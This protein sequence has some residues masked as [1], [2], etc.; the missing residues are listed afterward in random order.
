MGH[1]YSREFRG[2][3][4][5]A[6]GCS[7]WIFL[8]C[9]EATSSAAARACVVFGGLDADKNGEAYRDGG[10]R[11]VQMGRRGKERAGRAEWQEEVGD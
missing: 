11:V 8:V 5:A 6:D 7:K 2:G 1:F 3:R 10:V 4:E 9:N